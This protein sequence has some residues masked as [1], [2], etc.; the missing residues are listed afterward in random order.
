[1][2]KIITPTVALGM[3]LTAGIL[4]APDASAKGHNQGMDSQTSETPGDNVGSETVANSHTEGTEQGNRPAD[5][6]PGDDNPAAD[7]ADGSRG[8][9]SA[10]GSERG[11]GGKN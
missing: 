1:M 5:K 6:G 10:S 3:A 7:R 8:G 11:G 2:I 9:N 4:L